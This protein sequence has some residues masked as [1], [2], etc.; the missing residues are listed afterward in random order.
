MGDKEVLGFKLE[1]VDCWRWRRF[2]NIQVNRG[3][4]IT[5]VAQTDQPETVRF[6]LV[7]FTLVGE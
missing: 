7:E 1:D 4:K 5:L 6:D 3:D 2:E